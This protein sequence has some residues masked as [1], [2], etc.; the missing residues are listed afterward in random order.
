MAQHTAYLTTEVRLDLWVRLYLFVAL[1]LA[2]YL[3]ITIN[4]DTVIRRV[5][6]G[7]RIMIKDGADRIIAERACSL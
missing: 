1:A 4:S 5:S 7:T 3:G 6:R 2:R